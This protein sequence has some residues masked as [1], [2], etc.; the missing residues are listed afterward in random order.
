METQLSYYD[1]L[2]NVIPG[3]FVLWAVGNV[4]PAGTIRETISG[5]NLVADSIVFLVLA[6]ILGQVIQWLAKFTIEAVVKRVFWHRMF[7][8]DLFLV[9]GAGWCRESERADYLRLA[10]DKVG[11]DRH[12]ISRL[13][14][15]G[16]SEMSPEEIEGA[17]STCQTIFRR[18]ESLAADEGIGSKAI[19]QN[20]FYSLFRGLSLSS[21]LC[22]FIFLVGYAVRAG[23]SGLILGIM[24]LGAAAIFVH[25]AKE[26][27][28]LYVT[29]VFNSVAGHFAKEMSKLSDEGR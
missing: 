10:K 19:L 18:F 2:A 28:E 25:R 27:G 8:S 14:S 7:P 4:L 11:I 26:R 20:T 16:L 13:Q 5:D 12:E 15:L 22:A 9:K 1:L 3:V 6:F 23:L 17:K 29:G 24:C 21:A